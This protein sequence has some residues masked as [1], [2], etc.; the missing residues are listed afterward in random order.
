MFPLFTGFFIPTNVLSASPQQFMNRYTMSNPALYL[1]YPVLTG[2]G[3]FVLWAGLF[4]YL[5]SPKGR[6]C[7]IP[8]VP[9]ATPPPA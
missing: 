3:L 2:I 4:Y 6:A 5:A 1:L 7:R 9:T 8:A